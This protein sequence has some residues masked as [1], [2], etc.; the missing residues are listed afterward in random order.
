M[1][2]AFLHAAFSGPALDVSVHEHS[3]KKGT[4]CELQLSYLTAMN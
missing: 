4:K 3:A 1:S 2:P